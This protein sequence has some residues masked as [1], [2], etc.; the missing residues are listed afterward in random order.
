MNHGSAGAWDF[1]K[2]R[3]QQNKL[4]W[5][6]QGILNKTTVVIFRFTHKHVVNDDLVFS[7]QQK[8]P[9]INTDKSNRLVIESHHGPTTV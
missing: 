4:K 5:T 2:C 9:D 3:L 1:Y 7:T 6:M 8:I